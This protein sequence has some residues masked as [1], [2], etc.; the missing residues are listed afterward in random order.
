MPSQKASQLTNRELRAAL[1]VLHAIGEGCAGGADFAARGVKWLPRLVASELTTLS[2]CDLDQGHRSVVSDQPGAISPR[3]IEVFNCHFHEHP[4]VRAHGRDPGAV[5]RRITDCVAP[6]AFRASALYNEYY[7]AIRIDHVIAVPI[8]VDHRF[9]VSFVLNRSRSGFGD[10]ERELLE[11]ARP[12]LANLYRLGI[13][14][15]RVR[16]VPADISFDIASVPLTPREREVLDWVAAGKTN[17]DIAAILGARPR[18]VEKHLERIYEKLGVETR[19]AA[20]MR[21]VKLFRPH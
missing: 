2:V 6:E 17:R 13:A 18:T 5:T 14:A 1:E 3:A 12:H 4:L 9:L 15:D 19:T 11:I 7:R 10:R 20:A 21:A 8:Y 16:E